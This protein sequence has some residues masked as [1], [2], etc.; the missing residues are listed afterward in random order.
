M[1]AEEMVITNAQG[2]QTSA[3]KIDFYLSLPGQPR[4]S[5]ICTWRAPVHME[6]GNE[7]IYIQVEDWRENYGTNLFIMDEITGRIYAEN[8]SRYP[9]SVVIGDKRRLC[10]PHIQWVLPLQP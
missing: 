8:C 5:E 1:V 6:Q 3:L 9:K 4:I 2:Q 7:S 10:L